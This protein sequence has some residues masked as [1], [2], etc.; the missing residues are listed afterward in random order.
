MHNSSFTV[1]LE[2]ELFVELET[3]ELESGVVVITVVLMTIDTWVMSLE[4]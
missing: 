2:E 3:E 1:L 4:T